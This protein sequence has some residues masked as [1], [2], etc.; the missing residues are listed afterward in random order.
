MRQK[1][2]HGKGYVTKQGYHL[3][4]TGE[5]YE[6]THRVLLLES[7]VEIPE[8]HVVHHIDGDKLNNDLSNLIVCSKTEHRSLHH[9]LE[10]VSM[11]LVRSGT[12]V[13]KEGKYIYES[14]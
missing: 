7:G 3:T 5:R 2:P 11:A 12:I 9:Q 13:F 10:E 4:W 14:K 8:G 1:N 6:P